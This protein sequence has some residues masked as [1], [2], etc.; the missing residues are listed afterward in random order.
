MVQITTSLGGILAATLDGRLGDLS[1]WYKLMGQFLSPYIL[2]PGLWFTARNEASGVSDQVDWEGLSA[3]C[4][5][6]DRNLLPGH[7]Y[8]KKRE[9]HHDA[10]RGITQHDP[11]MDY[12]SSEVSC[13]LDHSGG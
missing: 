7:Q 11:K 8:K 6:I 2:M 3:W 13:I 4:V 10:H 5:N 1:F 12:V 9:Y